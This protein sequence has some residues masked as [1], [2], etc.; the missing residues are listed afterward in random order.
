MTRTHLM[1]AASAVALACISTAS[2]A[3]PA[4]I[5]GGGSTLAGF[6]YPAEFTSFN[7]TK[8]VTATFSTY[9]LSGSGTG[10]QAFLQDDLSC[11]ISRAQTGT[12][13]CN[14]NGGAPGNTV[15]YGASDATLSGTQ[16]ATWSTSTFGQS[17]AGNLIQIPS[18]GV[19]I[20]IPV[21]ETI[22]G[23]ALTTN[24]QL[25]LSDN[26]LCGIFSGLI[27]N[28]NQITD[29]GAALDAGNFKV[30]YRSDGS[31]TSFILT[32][33]L[34]AVCKTGT[35]GNSA[36]T[37]S[38][39]TSFASLFG[40][41]PPAQ[42]VGKSG[43][44][45]V[46]TYLEGANCAGGTPLP[47]AI[48]YISPD[49]TTEYPNSGATVCSAP[50][51]IP[52]TLDIAAVYT[53]AQQLLPTIANIVKGLA[54]PGA[55]ATNPTPPANATAAADPTKWVPAI[56]VV[57]AGYALVGYTTW[58]FAQC[59]ADVKVATAIKKFLT[60]HYT[61]AG[62]KAIQQ[63]NGFVPVSNSGAA[64]FYTAISKD[65]ITNKNGYKTDIQDTTAC[66]GLVG[67]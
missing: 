62:Y 65:I 48:G 60:S 54:N 38:A 18:M 21:D 52:S 28:F 55:G 56:P 34:A 22:G 29:S 49:Y 7:A 2:Y 40:G 41:T 33:H 35:G 17:A 61:G 39:T 51:Q 1:G 27:T 12:T 46:A 24:G 6:D 3:Q 50:N 4:T 19:G 20:A 32:Q 31:G 26:D 53:G 15:D 16:I 59:Y 9:W 37:F 43:S 63:L 8:G 36:I 23:V 67:R 30:A 14:G 47:Q 13:T 45:G 5:L 10:Q 44:G 42:F 64:K 58:D 66:K 25:T 11:D 57:K